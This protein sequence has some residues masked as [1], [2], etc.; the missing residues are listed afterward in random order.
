[1]YVCMYV[2]MCVCV[3]IYIYISKFDLI[4]EERK[5]LFLNFIKRKKLDHQKYFLSKKKK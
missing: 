3:Y 1:M 4:L 5:K 2:C